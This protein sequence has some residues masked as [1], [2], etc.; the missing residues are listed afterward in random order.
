MTDQACKSDCSA[1]P[2]WIRKGTFGT[3]C[4]GGASLILERWPYG[5]SFAE[6]ASQGF[7]F[8]GLITHS[9]A[10][11]Y[12]SQV[13]FRNFSSEGVRHH[14]RALRTVGTPSGLSWHPS[15]SFR[16]RDFLTLFEGSWTSALVQARPGFPCFPCKPS[17]SKPCS[18]VL[19]EEDREDGVPPERYRPR[20]DPPGLRR[21][22]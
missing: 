19:G 11:R 17:R 9:K 1:G 21:R 13:L 6:V 3:S 10:A 14:K 5:P 8:S 4:R 22:R 7:V 2:I 20:G 18:H 12:A 16:S 15:P